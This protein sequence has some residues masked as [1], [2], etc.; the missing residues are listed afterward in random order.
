M[1]DIDHIQNA[2][3]FIDTEIE[4]LEGPGDVRTRVFCALSDVA[5]EHGKSI[6]T[7][8]RQELYSSAYALVRVMLETGVRSL[9]LSRCATEKELIRY[10]E[11]D[12]IE[13]LHFRAMTRVVDDMYKLGGVLIDTQ[14]KVW[15]S[16]HSYTHGGILQVRKRLKGGVVTP[17]WDEKSERNL[18]QL[19]ALVLLVVYTETLNVTNPE[20]REA[21]AKRI[22]E[23]L[24][25][26]LISPNES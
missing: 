4:K 6:Y 23:L 10:I 18:C 8:I 12:E 13:G 2:L 3:A 1:N 5:M 25:N 15:G 16:A 7:L 17:D 19:I 11:K 26:V 20:N 22:D 9:W 14:K 21:Q 24:Q